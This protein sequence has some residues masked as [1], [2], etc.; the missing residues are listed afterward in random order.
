MPA[1]TSDNLG[2]NDCHAA[3][4]ATCA[5]INIAFRAVLVVLRAA[6]MRRCELP[7]LLH[8]AVAAWT[9]PSL[10]SQNTYFLHNGTFSPIAAPLRHLSAAFACLR[11]ATY[12]CALP[13]SSPLH[14]ELLLTTRCFCVGT[15]NAFSYTRRA[16]AASITTDIL[17]H[18]LATYTQAVSYWHDDTCVNARKD[19]ARFVLTNAPRG[20][21]TRHSLRNAGAHRAALPRCVY[22]CS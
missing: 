4:R 1:G 12:S 3:W 5:V 15:Q 19:P 7:L 17:R 13:L 8:C 18:N 16:F 6:D 20:I 11:N 10:C 9:V 14:P 22:G 21:V 2:D